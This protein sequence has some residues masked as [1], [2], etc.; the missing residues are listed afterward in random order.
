MTLKNM[1]A[2]GMTFPEECTVYL[3][4]SY[5]VIIDQKRAIPKGWLNLEIKRI[6][7]MPDKSLVIDLNN[8]K[9]SGQVLVSEK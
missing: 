5:G 7:V 6:Q 9:S 8:R 4:N 2:A 1:I 3:L